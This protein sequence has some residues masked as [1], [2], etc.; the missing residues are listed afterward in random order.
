MLIITIIKLVLLQVGR[1][2]YLDPLPTGVQVVAFFV[3]V[4]LR[5]GQNLF[6]YWQANGFPNNWQKS[7]VKKMKKFKNEVFRFKEVLLREVF[8][9]DVIKIKYCEICP[10]DI[11]ILDTSEQRYNDNILKT[12]ERRIKGENRIRIKRAVRNLELRNR[13]TPQNN[14]DYLTRLV[15]KL[16]GLIEYDPP[17]A[18]DKSFSGVFK[19][20]NDPIVTTM[21]EDNILFC[22][23]KLYSKEVVGMVLYNGDNTKVLQ[24]NYNSSLGTAKPSFKKS[25]I[26]CTIDRLAWL[27]FSL[28]V[29]SG[30]I[31]YIILLTESGTVEIVN[32]IESAFY[33]GATVRKFFVII[34]VL[35]N[36]VPITL[37]IVHD[38]YCLIMSLDVKYRKVD[39]STSESKSGQ[40]NAAA[41]EEK[42]A[43][44]RLPRRDGRRRKSGPMGKSIGHSFLSN[45][46]DK[47]R[48]KERRLAQS[49][50]DDRVSGMFISPRATRIRRDTK[51]PSEGDMAAVM[52]LKDKQ[53]QDTLKV[54]EKTFVNIT[55]YAVLSDLGNIDQVVIDKTDTLTSGMMRVSELSTLIRCYQ[56]PSRDIESLMEE[57]TSNP[58]TFSYEDQLVNNLESADYSEKSQEYAT[59][60]EGEYH[61]EVISEDASIS[62]LVDHNIFP[63][64]VNMGQKHDGMSN[65]NMSVSKKTSDKP[66]HDLTLKSI[67]SN[68][69]IPFLSKDSSGAPE[70]SKEVK[71]LNALEKRFKQSIG[72]AVNEKKSSK[73]IDLI[74]HTTGNKGSRAA[75]LANTMVGDSF[76]SR[77]EEADLSQE[78]KIDFKVDKKLT[79]KNFIHDVVFQKEHTKDLME[80]LMMV[81]ECSSSDVKTVRSMSLEDRAISDMLFK[82]QYEIK[83]KV[84]STEE[85]ETTPTNKTLSLSNYSTFHVIFK[86]YTVKIYDVIC[87]NAYTAHRGR[88]SIILRDSSTSEPEFLLFVKG[89]DTSFKNHF[90]PNNM[91]MKELNLLKSMLTV[92]RIQG[93]KRVMIGMKKLTERE[94]RD[95]LEIYNTISESS[96]EQLDTFESHAD[97]LEQN[98]N[99]VGCLGLKDIVREEAQQLT[100]DLDRAKMQVNILSGDTIDNCLNVAKELGL[101]Q[102]NF[103]DTS[104]YFSINFRSEKQGILDLRR[105]LDSI[106][107]LLLDMNLAKIEEMLDKD[108]LDD[109]KGNNNKN[110]LHTKTTMKEK[111]EKFPQGA[112][113]TLLNLDNEKKSRLRRT[114]VICGA[115][116]NI[117]VGSEL[118]RS[119]LKTILLFS[120]CVIGHTM[121]PAHKAIIVMLFKELNQTVMAIGDG[122]ND[123]AMFNYADVSIQIVNKDVPFI[124]GDI[125]IA[126]LNMVRYVTLCLGARI[127]NNLLALFLTIIWINTVWNCVFAYCLTSTLFSNAIFNT[128]QSVLPLALISIAGVFYL[129]VDY[130]YTKFLLI[131]NPG[132]YFERKI[133]ITRLSKLLVLMFSYSLL[134]SFFI[135]VSANLF[136]THAIYPNGSF[137]GRSSLGLLLQWTMGSLGLLKIYFLHWRPTLPHSIFYIALWATL[138]GGLIIEILTNGTFSLSSQPLAGLFANLNIYFI[139]AFILGALGLFSYVMISVVKNYF[140][141][142]VSPFLAKNIVTRGA[143]FVR[144]GLDATAKKIVRGL[145]PNLLKSDPIQLIRSCYTSSTISDQSI[146]RILSLDFFNFTLPIDGLHR[147]KD[148]TDRRKFKKYRSPNENFYTILY[149]SVTIVFNLIEY[150]MFIFF[151][152]YRGNYMLDNPSVYGILIY[153]FLLMFSF[154]DLKHSLLV[155]INTACNAL[156]VAVN[157]FFITWKL[158]LQWRSGYFQVTKFI[159]AP[160]ASNFLMSIATMLI[161]DVYFVSS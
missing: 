32:F 79:D 20:K 101:S 36:L 48:Q 116:L 81:I 35:L 155:R 83:K 140:F 103:S 111:E 28:A 91:G 30:S 158:N 102:C 24:K 85:G 118:L 77:A 124:L 68:G 95:Y 137:L 71:Q 121:Q 104:S 58:E 96:R 138:T 57:C 99:F 115:S 108:K 78:M 14:S 147:I 45:G 142:P 3:L 38:V 62:L 73:K 106:Y 25:K 11:L 159:M 67:V 146:Q 2:D 127:H 26:M 125:Q 107:E 13:S 18:S 113:E 51:R 29:L 40:V 153:V 149:N 39:F 131:S 117:V 109:T 97:K 37:P 148:I 49:R 4:V 69:I 7:H 54:F 122:F 132:L 44:L 65:L 92:Y 6:T 157:I 8:V 112:N 141:H 31:L 42:I 47:E 15:Q 134:E 27:F 64:Y 61:R 55:N 19:L 23:S 86:R 136:L 43:K 34:C 12:N 94:V 161:N 152:N 110:S 139:L 56:V 151:A 75:E 114:L 100:S 90:N 46:S 98:L 89:E 21:T 60:L 133:I 119:Y 105:M 33:Q 145:V 93:L 129:I 72:M 22:G 52:N 50:L 88:M 1:A 84:T 53:D 9:G 63:N 144:N 154:S 80:I 74:S 70:M 130:P 143:E 17:S 87:V 10:F 126:D 160:I 76:Y 41:H 120:N 16:N 156:F 135:Y 66:F 128:N 59:E 82:L 150:I 123:L 5:V